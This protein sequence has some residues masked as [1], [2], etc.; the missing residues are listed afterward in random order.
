[1]NRHQRRAAQVKQ[2]RDPLC[3]CCNSRRV[4]LHFLEHGD[5]IC[6]DGALAYVTDD[7]DEQ[8]MHTV[9]DFGILTVHHFVTRPEPEAPPEAHTSTVWIKSFGQVVFDTDDD[10]PIREPGQWQATLASIARQL[11]DKYGAI[12]PPQHSVH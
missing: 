1:M 6:A 4:I 2:G 11:D 5:D 12:N 9:I 10:G 3:P 8:Q 7:S